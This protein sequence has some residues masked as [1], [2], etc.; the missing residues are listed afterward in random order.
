MAELEGRWETKTK[1]AEASTK[2]SK[3]NYR[4]I[5]RVSFHRVSFYAR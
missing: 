1:R 2:V 5:S 3:I 4:V